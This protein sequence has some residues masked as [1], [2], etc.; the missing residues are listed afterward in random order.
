MQNILILMGGVSTEHDISLITGVQAIN[1]IDKNKY[2]IYPVVIDKLGKW[3]F[4]KDFQN[5]KNIQKYFA[6]KKQKG[7]VLLRDKILYYILKNKLKKLAS[8][9][10]VLFC[11]HGGTGENGAIQGFIESMN[12]PHTAPGHTFSG[13][14][15]DKYLSKIAFGKLGIESVKCIKID[16]QKYLDEKVKAIEKVKQN[17]TPPYF[18]KPNSQGSSI[19]I[20]KANTTSKLRECIEDAFCYDEEVLVEETVNNLYELN[21]AV[22]RKNGKTI[23]SLIERPA[24]KNKI[25]SFGDKYLSGGKRGLDGMGRELPAKLTPEMESYIKESAT[26]IYDNFI[27]K[28]VVRIDYLVDGKTQK[29]YAGEVNTIPGSLSFYLWEGQMTFA[30]LLSAMID[31]AIM[32][33]EKSSRLRKSFDSSVLDGFSGAKGSKMRL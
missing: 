32:Q 23:T 31:D 6:A 25:L 15:M 28:G 1:N 11:L 30:E 20:S 8:I 13:I 24:N 33:N 27:K 12:L 7:E 9:D 29:V 2:A 16:K 18:V 21:I 19:G 10:C 26:K 4:S 3:H 17:I 14:F 5:I 22:T